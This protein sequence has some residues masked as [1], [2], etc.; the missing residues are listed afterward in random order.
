METPTQEIFDEMKQI[1][2]EIWNTYDNQFGYVDEKLNRIN[3]FG[4]IEDNA[5]VMYRMFDWE[6]Q[7]LFRKKSS[8]EVIR[9]INNNL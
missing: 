1:S 3:S 6:N 7:S 5:M 2:T 9:Y 4:N 8:E